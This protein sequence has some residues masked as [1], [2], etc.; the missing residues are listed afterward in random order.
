[1]G[2]ASCRECVERRAARPVGRGAVQQMGAP[3]LRLLGVSNRPVE[4][5]EVEEAVMTMMMM[6]METMEVRGRQERREEEEAVEA[7]EEEEAEEAAE[8]VEEQL[9]ETPVILQTM[10]RTQTQSQT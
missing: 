8:A 9:G 10:G 2:G 5:E 7:E 1:M 6:A 3:L 4:G